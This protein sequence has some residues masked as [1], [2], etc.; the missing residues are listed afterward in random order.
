MESI[1]CWSRE[2]AG[3]TFI[4][5]LRCY[6][7]GI[8]SQK[9]G[10]T[11]LKERRLQKS[12]GSLIST[13]HRIEKCDRHRKSYG[14][15]ESVQI[16]STVFLLVSWHSVSVRRVCPECGISKGSGKGI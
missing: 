10:K 1:R 7:C 11:A 15:A 12:S 5:M 16:K 9:T 14:V 3:L 8:C 4:G 6:V 2:K 13:L